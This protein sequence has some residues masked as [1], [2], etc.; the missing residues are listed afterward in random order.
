MLSSLGDCLYGDAQRTDRAILHMM[1]QQ[2]QQNVMHYQHIVQIQQQKKIP[3]NIQVGF[4][5]FF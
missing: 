5:I 4:W 3:I 2:S 1:Q